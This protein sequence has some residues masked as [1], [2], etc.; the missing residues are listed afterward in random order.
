M[1]VGILSRRKEGVSEV[2]SVLPLESAHRLLPQTP[3]SIL[4]R[5]EE[6]DVTEGYDRSKSHSDT[7]NKPVRKFSISRFLPKFR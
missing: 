2:L 3:L 7:N 5:V 6:S 4:T 1:Q